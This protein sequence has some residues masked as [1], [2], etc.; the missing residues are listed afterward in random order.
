[1]CLPGGELERS[2][3]QDDRTDR[4][5]CNARERRLLH[6]DRRRDRDCGRNKDRPKASQRNVSAQCCYPR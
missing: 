6:L 1:M 2:G 3:D 4:D 5:R